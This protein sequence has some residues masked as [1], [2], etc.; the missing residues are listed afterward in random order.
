MI[1]RDGR[2]GEASPL[3]SA[4]WTFGEGHFWVDFV[5]RRWLQDSAQVSTLGALNQQVSPE[6]A[7]G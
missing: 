7:R 1:P 5:P 3:C 6:G 2:V 4:V